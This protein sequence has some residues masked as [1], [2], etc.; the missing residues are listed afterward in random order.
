M[1][2]KHVMGLALALASHAAFAQDRPDETLAKSGSQPHAPSMAIVEASIQC[3]DA[4]AG[5]G[6]VRGVRQYQQCN[7][8]AKRLENEVLSLAVTVSKQT[9]GIE[10]GFIFTN[11][12]I[13][14]QRKTV[15]MKAASAILGEYR[16][17]NVGVACT[18]VGLEACLMRNRHGVLLSNLNYAGGLSVS[19]A[20]SWLSILPQYP[21]DPR[22]KTLLLDGRF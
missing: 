12:T 5:V 17:G 2:T 4:V 3:A 20:Y 1:F 13:H 19:L 18:I 22:W 14:I 7:F 6:L 8:T 21:N 11:P 15:F 9:T 16:G 10:A